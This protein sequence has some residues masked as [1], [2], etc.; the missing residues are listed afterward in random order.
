M[1]DDVVSCVIQLLVSSAG[2]QSYMVGQLWTALEADASD[3]QP[4]T[5]VATWC[6]GEYGDLLLYSPEAPVKVFLMY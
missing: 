4:L 5:Q 1:R 2:H 3:R 6:I